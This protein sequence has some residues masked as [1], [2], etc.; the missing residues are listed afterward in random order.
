MTNTVADRL[1]E[2][3]VALPQTPPEGKIREIDTLRTLLASVPNPNIQV[4]SAMMNDSSDL[5]LEVRAYSNAVMCLRCRF[6]P[7]GMQIKV[8]RRFYHID[9][10]PSLR[11][12]I[13]VRVRV[14]I[15]SWLETP[16]TKLIA[17]PLPSY[18]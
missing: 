6:A 13:E 15:Q 2:S 3:L 12:G 17:N 16:V 1:I 9:A 18:K 7:A 5:Q 10:N 8:M 11:L 4:V 14:A